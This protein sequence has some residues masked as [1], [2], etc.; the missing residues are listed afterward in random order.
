[1]ELITEDKLVYY[2]KEIQI[3]NVSWNDTILILPQVEYCYDPPFLWKVSLLLIVRIL[4]STLS[5][6]KR[7]LI[8]CKS[9]SFC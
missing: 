3:Q 7:S 4:C 2:L 5:P 1:M 6:K 8:S 9:I